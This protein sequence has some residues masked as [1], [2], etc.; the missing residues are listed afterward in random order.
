MFKLIAL[1]LGM[2]R[3]NMCRNQT[4]PV[5]RSGTENQNKVEEWRIKLL[6]GFEHQS[7]KIKELTQGSHDANG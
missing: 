5:A 1:D 3:F 7:M 6:S 4:I 2:V